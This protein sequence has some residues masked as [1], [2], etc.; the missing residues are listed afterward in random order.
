V[1]SSSATTID[2]SALPQLVVRTLRV[3]GNLGHQ[4]SAKRGSIRSIE[5]R[6]MPP[7]TPS[8]PDGADHQSERPTLPLF[9][10]ERFGAFVFD[11]PEAVEATE[12]MHTVHL[13]N[14]TA[15]TF[16]AN[17]FQDSNSSGAGTRE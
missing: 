4:A 6:N 16:S 5:W 3:V 1:V 13:G 14:P 12:V 11:R 9:S 8:G 10:E 2:S 7:L 17:L 15:I